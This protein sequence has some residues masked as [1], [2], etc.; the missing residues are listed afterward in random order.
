LVGGEIVCSP[1][2]TAICSTEEDA[3]D[4]TCNGLDDNCDGNVDEGFDTGEACGVGACAGGVTVC[5]ESGT[6]TVC[7]T[8][9]NATDETCNE[10][11]DNCDGETDEGVGNIYFIDQDHDEFGDPT[12]EPVIA[13]E[14]PPG[15]V[16]DNSDCDDTA[17]NTY[18]GAPE[19]CDGEDNNCQGEIDE[20]IICGTYGVPVDGFPN[21]EERMFLV[22][23]N[24]ARLQRLWFKSTFMSDITE[25]VTNVFTGN[26]TDTSPLYY[27]LNLSKSSRHHSK[28]MA[29]NNYFSHYSQDDTLFADDTTPFE[30]MAYFGHSTYPMGEN[31]GASYNPSPLQMVVQLICDDMNFDDTCE[32]DGENTAGH[33]HNIM[34]PTFFLVGTGYAYNAASTYKNYYTHDLGGGLFEENPIPSASHIINPNDPSGD[35]LSFFLTYY[36]EAAGTLVIPP[37]ITIHFDGTESQ[38]SPEIQ[39]IYSFEKSISDLSPGCHEYY[40]TAED[41]N[42]TLWKYPEQGRFFTYGINGCETDFSL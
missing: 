12:T 21:W 10:L 16:E 24:M 18:P 38:L 8:A 34:E 41:S 31:L 25:D 4:E 9:G 26:Y 40:F 23:T 39:G 28:S 22:A 13:C 14:A 6:E 32:P 29:D 20:G 2:G 17:K 30:R 11:D 42:G 33:R 37:S 1:D 7:S 19:I 36:E 35:T 15:Y 3:T 27:S 5:S